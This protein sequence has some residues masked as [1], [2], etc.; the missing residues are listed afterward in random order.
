MEPFDSHFARLYQRIGVPVQTTSAALLARA[1]AARSALGSQPHTDC[2]ETWGIDRAAFAAVTSAIE[3]ARTA[4][5]RAYA[6]YSNFRVGAAVLD[7]HQQV[8]VGANVENASYG[9]TLCAERAALCAA[10][11]GG[12]GSVMLLC[13]VADTPEPIAPCGACRQWIIELAP[14]AIVAMISTHQG[15]RWLPAAE[16]LPFAFDRNMFHPS[17]EH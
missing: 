5:E 11:V 4:R 7:V 15:E 14:S 9:L 10:Q 1:I 8:W 6:P 2:W 12:A 17:R 16:L 13:V 3:A